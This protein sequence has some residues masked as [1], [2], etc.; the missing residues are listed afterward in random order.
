MKLSKKKT[1]RRIFAILLLFALA[2]ARYSLVSGALRHEGSEGS[3]VFSFLDVGQG[4][5]IL[6]SSPAGDILVDTGPDNAEEALLHTLQA[7]GV[8][9]LRMLFLSHGDSDHAG[10]ADTVLRSF[11]VRTLYLPQSG[12]V[13]GA[14]RAAERAAD[15]EGTRV[16]RLSAGDG[17]YSGEL[18]ITVLSPFSPPEGEENTD[19]LVLRVTYGETA[20]LLTGDADIAAEERILAACAPDGLRCNLLKL[21]HHGSRTSTS[22]A[23]LAAVRPEYAVISCGKANAFG[24]PHSE[25]LLRLQEEGICVLRTD[26]CGEIRFVSDG[27]SICRE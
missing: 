8:T 4:D 15:D 5:A 24:H 18:C 9:D 11:P 13:S 23:F 1:Y 12:S 17:L 27:K 26:E 10:N 22:P 25:T 20:V 6:I 3:V 2:A 19:S 7:R 16:S 21:G 14:V